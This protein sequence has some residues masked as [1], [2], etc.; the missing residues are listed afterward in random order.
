MIKFIDIVIIF[1]FNICICIIDGFI[2]FLRCL[3]III[4]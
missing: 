2:G 3:Y 4:F 1:V